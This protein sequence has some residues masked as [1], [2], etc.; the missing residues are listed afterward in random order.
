MQREQL[1]GRDA[2]LEAIAA[3]L[4]RPSD[5]LPAALV[6]EGEAGIGKTVLWRAGVDQAR[7]GEG[8]VLASRLAPGETRLAF[9]ALADL[10]EE[11]W[12][13]VAD[14]IAAPQRTALERA[15]L[16]REGTGS[17]PDERAVA[18]GFLGLVRA[19]ARV[20]P[21][22]IAIDDI[23]WLDP[24]SAAM[25]RYAL[26]RVRNEP[27]RLL[28]AR[29]LEGGADPD[30]LR[31]EQAEGI[32]VESLAIGPLTL[33]ALH[34]LLRTRLG[35]PLTRPALSRIHAASNGNPLHAL[36]LSRALES[37]IGRAPG[38][39]PALMRARVLALP[40]EARRVLLLVSLAASPSLAML[41]RAGITEPEDTLAPAIHAELV[42]LHA[43]VVRFTHPLI[44]AAAVEIC[45]ESE[46]RWGHLALV[47][48]A[49][50]DEE[51][52]RHLG[53]GADG[54]DE[55]I[56]SILERSAALARRRGATAVSAELYEEAA[57]LTPETETARRGGLL[58]EAGYALVDAGDTDRASELFRSLVHTLPEGL[59][60]VE[61]RW[62][63]GAV[64]DETGHTQEATR[65]W[66]E[67][68]AATTDPRLT[69]E[70]ERSLAYT[71]VYTGSAPEATLHAEA[72]V[73][74]A[75]RSGD[76]QTLAYAL[77]ARALIA[78]LSGSP[79]F[80]Q[81][82]QRALDLEGRL[83]EPLKE[84]SPTAVAAE[85]GR[86]T[87]RI[88]GTCEA[89]EAVMAQA[90]EVGDVSTEQWAAFG[91]SSTEL[92]T[93]QLDR[94][95]TFSDVVLEL[96]DQTQLMRIPAAALA[97]NVAAH[98]GDL[99]SA[100]TSVLVA[101]AEA[102]AAEERMYEFTILHGLGFIEASRGDHVAAAA[103]YGRAGEVAKELGAR[104][105]TVLR[106]LLHESE[107]AAAAGLLEQAHEALAEY[108]RMA[109]PPFEPQWLANLLRRAGAAIAAAEGDLPRARTLLEAAIATP[110]AGVPIEE[111]RT[112]LAYGSLLRRMREH[113][114]ARVELG[115]AIDEFE[116]LG[117]IAWARQAS[118][119]LARIPGRTTRTQGELTDAERRIAE[120][121]AAGRSNKEVAAALHITVKTVEVT[122]TRVYRKLAVRS[123]S[124]LAAR[125]ASEPKR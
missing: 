83:D 89:Y 100:R 90:V 26:R 115:D 10:I 62:R 111:A 122:L 49:T 76:T 68:L 47:A 101:L 93:G 16:L 84:W 117:T 5:R 19:L 107:A 73:A 53:R 28:L 41:V 105:A 17:L 1:I 39:L 80:E 67:A 88:E 7:V 85:C 110:D 119:E 120:L 91:L 58:I 99:D 77:G 114:L 121:V 86:L 104:H 123:R 95:R 125:F 116:R 70:L 79:D 3:F 24:S 54:P 13:E 113:A 8:T 42:T 32:V 81:F 46:Q 74:A 29:R 30:P 15:L 23:Q 50:T 109:G 71:T 40:V 35:H 124:E 4:A 94:A 34:R 87:G 78:V 14:E 108:G 118:A 6:L 48:A 44:A 20:G 38:S 82:L 51:R 103:I 2:E 96:A 12:D 63:L 31:I 9:A 56:A 61:A 106:T 57:A 64:L 112:K 65:T 43:G 66:Q 72:S 22:T 33:G 69:A 92:L 27:V 102:Q 36:E 97:A 21:L 18:F 59:E 60:R 52:A 25:L 37:P 55:E 75:E 98:V 45:D 11:V